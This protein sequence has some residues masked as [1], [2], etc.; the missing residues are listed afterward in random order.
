MPDSKVSSK[1][2]A[3]VLGALLCL[4]SLSFA[5]TPEEYEHMDD[6][7]KFGVS[8]TANADQLKRAYRKLAS[9]YLPRGAVTS[10]EN[11]KNSEI[12]AILNAAYDRLSGR[13]EGSKTPHMDDS[14]FDAIFGNGARNKKTKRHAITIKL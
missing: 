11:R 1:F 2:S 10:E 9:K 5:I 8:S 6:Y 14:L 3:A 7:Q 13:N 12:M 4:G